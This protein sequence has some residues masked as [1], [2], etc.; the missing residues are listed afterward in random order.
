[1][2]EFLLG[3]DNVRRAQSQAKTNEYEPHTRTLSFD[4]LFI[5]GL[6]ARIA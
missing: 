5:V 2:H 6:Y 4:S 3:Q 1:M